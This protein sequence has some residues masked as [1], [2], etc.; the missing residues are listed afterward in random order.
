MQGLADR[1]GSPRTRFRIRRRVTA[2]VVSDNLKSGMTQACFYES[3]VN[4]S[5][6]EMAAGALS[7]GGRSRCLKRQIGNREPECKILFRFTRSFL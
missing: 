2:M 5:C 7:D 4:R 3:T 1:I 6:A